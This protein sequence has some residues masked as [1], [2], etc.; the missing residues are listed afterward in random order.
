MRSNLRKLVTS[1]L[2]GI[3]VLGLHQSACATE[4]SDP[5]Y[6]GLKGKKVI[7]IPI[8]MNYDITQAW[9]AG[10]KREA[11]RFGYEIIVRDPNW[12]T[13]AAVQAF[14]AAI[15][16]KPNLIVTL[17][18]DTTSLS[19]LVKRAQEDGIPV[20]EIQQ[21]TSIVPDVF[22]GSDWTSIGRN[23]AKA[24]AD[25]CHDYGKKA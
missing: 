9:L 1:A 15:R 10:M 20:I 24:A 4:P 3:A 14:Q 7:Y 22:V 25:A 6:A 2:V 12:D 16:E 17:P 21:I 19:R 18:P 5:G 11:E 23:N 8:S 13:N